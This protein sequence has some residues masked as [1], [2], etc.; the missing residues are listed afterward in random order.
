MTSY[1]LAALDMAG[2]TLDEGGLVY[3][4]LAAAVSDAAR[5]SMPPGLLAQWKG[6]AKS[7]AVTGLLR[8]LGADASPEAS[9]KVFA[10][11]TDRLIAAYRQ[12]PPRPF[13]GVLEMFE[14]LRSAG[15]A[16][17]LQT[18]YPADI[19]DSIMAGLAWPAGTVDA[20]ITS[21][22]VAAGRPAPYLIFHAMEA[23]GVTS[24]TQVLA[25]GDTPNDLQ[26]GSNAGAGFV[27]GVGTG[28]FRT[29]QLAASPHTHLLDD[30]TGL[31]VLL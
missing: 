20:V 9:A 1:S 18:G 16:I 21:D 27:V 12:T 24:V 14:V 5:A 25:A 6:A 15:V 11:F 2:T 7:E 8:G 31:P 3:E 26:A 10:D 19:A 22:Q 23:A 13:P 28:S 4:V 17:V 30:V 29:D